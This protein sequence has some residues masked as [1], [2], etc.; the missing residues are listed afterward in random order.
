MMKVHIVMFPNTTVKHCCAL[1]KFERLLSLDKII[2]G[3]NS[4]WLDK[5]VYPVDVN[6]CKLNYSE[7]ACRILIK[8]EF[9]LTIPLPKHIISDTCK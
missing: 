3:V 6:W 1:T 7:T 5:S 8:T 4:H 9:G 2:A